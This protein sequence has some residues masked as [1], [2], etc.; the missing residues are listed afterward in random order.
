MAS[1]NLIVD[2]SGANPE[3]VLLVAHYDTIGADKGSEG[4]TD[5][6]AGTSGLLAL[7]Q[8]LTTAE[9][10]PYSIRLLWTGAE[11]NGLNGALDYVAQGLTNGALD[12]VKAVI[13]FDTVGGGDFL[14]VHSA[15]EDYSEYE[16]RCKKLG[17]TNETYNFD[18]IVRDQLLQASENTEGIEHV[19]IIHPDFPGYPTGQTG[20]WSDHS[21]FA[22]AGIP[23]GY[24]ET[25]NFNI[26][27]Q[28]HYDGYSQTVNPMM[29]DCFNETTV[30]ACNRTSETKWG[31]I[32]HTEFD[33]LD[34]LEEA[35]PGRV[36]E[37]LGDTV[38]SVLTFLINGTFMDSIVASP[39]SAT[40]GIDGTTAATEGSYDIVA[41]AYLTA[42]TDEAN[43]GLG[44]RVTN[45]EQEVAAKEFLTSTLTDLG[46]EVLAIQAKLLP[47]LPRF[48]AVTAVDF[49][50]N[51][52]T[53]D[54]TTT[55]ASTNLIV[56]IP[57]ANP[58]IVLLV[59]HY[60]TTGADKGSEG[61]TDNH[62]DHNDALLVKLQI[63]VSDI[64]DGFY[65]TIVLIPVLIPH[66]AVVDIF[67]GA[68]SAGLLTLAQAVKATASIPY[69]IRLLWTGAEENG[70]NGALDYVASG[71]TNGDLDNVKA[72]I[73]F[74]TVGGGDF[75]YVHSAHEDY[76]EYESRCAKL[77]LTNATYTFDPIVRDQLLEASASTESVEH[78]FIIHPDFPGYPMGQTGSW[79]DHSPFAC[80]G[81]PIGYVETTNF[82]IDGLSHY[83]G[84]SQTVNPM[85]WD[86]FNETTVSAC[87]RTSETKW[88]KIWHTEFDRLDVL[89]EAF[90]GR[91]QEQLGDTVDS[92]I[93]FL[94]GDFMDAVVAAEVSKNTVVA[95]T[96][97]DTASEAEVDT[98]F[99]SATDIDAVTDNVE[100]TAVVDTDAADDTDMPAAT[101]TDAVT[102]LV[103]DTDAADD[104]D[105]VID[106]IPVATDT[107]TAAIPDVESEEDADTTAEAN[108]GEPA[109]T[110][111]GDSGGLSTGGIIGIIAAVLVVGGGAAVFFIYRKKQ[112]RS[113]TTESTTNL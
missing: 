23:I 70:L 87:N 34:V 101:D 95:D 74:D 39:L 68:G 6:G 10:I 37:Q 20:S 84:Y 36:Q 32:W 81:I 67:S 96:S 110:E 63:N 30:S 57:G 43:E 13:N 45:T 94:T 46:Y 66:S 77:G 91:V 12:N 104:T 75:L 48:A 107:E 14:Y 49:T 82:N 73:N 92:V 18:P 3:I 31:K 7:A 50:Y 47:V 15:H 2:I 98:D 103:V 90:P 61:A 54:V 29:W 4:A 69:T 24:V 85:M 58:E 35:F 51:K 64:Q 5:N 109:D 22:C 111:G 83:D 108:T 99:A 105:P 38:D 33:R 9:T 40:N 100:S 53:D 19:F 1:T 102:D 55:M 80:A 71:L 79:S 8:A 88:G 112:K 89:E 28:S 72:V 76:S 44:A 25:T 21:P 41:Y 17:L 86:C 97:M 56:D 78:I 113:Y 42:L 27:G 16:S 60:D 62:V 52:T 59:A 106:T 26:D 11:E 65:L 93:T